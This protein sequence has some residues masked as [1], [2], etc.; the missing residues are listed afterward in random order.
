MSQARSPGFETN[1]L[2]FQLRADDVQ[3]ALW[4]GYR[5]FKP[6][7]V[8]RRLSLNWNAS[9]HT[10]YGGEHLNVG[11]NMNGNAQFLNYWS[12]WG[13]ISA[14]SD[15][16]HVTA[17]RGGPAMFRPAGHNA[18]L[19]F[20]TDER[21]AVWMEADGSTFNQPEG[22][23]KIQSANV[24]VTCRVAS[25]VN[26][27]VGPSYEY[28]HDDWSYVTEEEAFNEP[29]YMMARLKQSTYSLTTRVNWTFRPN[30]SLQVYAAPFLSSGGYDDFKR[31]VEPRADKYDDM[32]DHLDY[33]DGTYEVD[34]DADGTS[35]FSFDD[36]NFNFQ[37][38]R[39]SVV[40]RWEYMPGSTIFFVYQ[41]DRTNETGDGVSQPWH[42]LGQLAD[43][44]GTNTVLV[45]I[46]Y[47]WSL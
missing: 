3:N 40:L 20:N 2:G 8:I 19:G 11:G 47:W 37:Q 6:G 12:M 17:L 32:F 28:L 14:D 15:G 36:P 45:K 22:L 26:F 24:L 46:N 4:F 35:D 1:D 27:S 43:A 10:N 9:H 23:T 21:K 31:V 33:A 39:S 29:Q 34:V 41:H 38:F 25:N 13:G 7:K 44:D 42:D 5:D 18:W 30:L 16:L